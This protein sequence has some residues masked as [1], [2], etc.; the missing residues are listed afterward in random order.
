MKS[1]WMFGF[2]AVAL[3]LAFAPSS[4]AQ[5][6]LQIFNTASPGEIATS[7]HANTSDP[8]SLGSGILVSGQLVAN[9]PLSSTLL[10]FTFPAPITSDPTVPSAD[11]IRIEGDTGVF[12][13]VEIVE[14]DAEDGTIMIELPHFPPSSPNTNSGSFR[15]VG[16]R[17]DANGKT[18][19]LTASVALSSSANNYIAPATPNFAIVSA[20]GAGI[21]SNMAVGNVDDQ[22]NL[23]TALVFTNQIGSSFAD[24]T[25]SLV[26]NEGIATG[27]RTA[28]QAST[29][30]VALPNGTQIR[31][32]VAGVPAG[33]TLNVTADDGDDEDNIPTVSISNS[34]M[35]NESTS[36]SRTVI[37]FTGVVGSGNEP[38]MTAIDR[39]QLNFNLTGVPTSLTAGP[40]TITAT[41][42]PVGDALD[43]DDEATVEDGFPRFAQANVGPVTI[44]QVVTAN[45]TLLI[46]YLV[47][48][49][50]FDTGIAIA[51][52]TADPFG[53]N[54]GGATASSG[55]IRVWLF[56]R[57][58]TNNGAGTMRTITTSATVRPGLGLSSDGTLA[59]GGTWSVLLGELW[60]AA[61]QTG[62]FFGYAFIQT[63]FLL[64]H[65]TSFIFDGRGFTSASPVLVLTPPASQPRNETEGLNN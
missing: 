56:P 35:T 8:T 50:F 24:A 45:T 23:G 38:N 2:L 13:G 10:T 46:P 4:Y 28:V 52:T 5:I 30:G 15:L 47:K 29:S 12:Q 36:D 60:T 6:Q 41:M 32:Q 61:G 31:L 53:A 43:D 3:V 11:P 49:G 7:R 40:I 39:I 21:N 27:W 20:L 63:D 22:D 44:G 34:T 18:A 14:M 17:F 42:W 55:P 16:V 33:A 65:G 37:S 59:A 48:F 19:P 25:A 54:S 1:K 26:I 51:N 64:A 62:D 58:A 57:N 9:S